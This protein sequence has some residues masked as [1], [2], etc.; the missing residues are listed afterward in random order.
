MPLYEDVGRK[1][2]YKFG[3]VLTIKEQDGEGALPEMPCD[4]LGKSHRVVLCEDGE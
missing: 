1:C 3:E 2:H 4:R